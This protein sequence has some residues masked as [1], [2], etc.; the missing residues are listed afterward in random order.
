MSSKEYICRSLK[1]PHLVTS[2]ITLKYPPHLKVCHS[3]ACLSQCL[4][5]QPKPTATAAFSYWTLPC[6]RRIIHACLTLLT[7]LPGQGTQAGG[8]QPA[9]RRRSYPEPLPAESLE[10]IWPCPWASPSQRFVI[11]EYHPL[12]VISFL[13]Q[14][15]QILLFFIGKS[16]CGCEHPRHPPPYPTSLWS[17]G[18]GLRTLFQ[19]GLQRRLHHAVEEQ[20]CLLHSLWISTELILFFLSRSHSWMGTVNSKIIAL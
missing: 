12:C 13:R 4:L 2:P 11:T 9:A 17:G 14:R 16:F 1:C 18:T 3:L 15:V 7:L 19:R 8:Q 5:P 20:S 10:C 6:G